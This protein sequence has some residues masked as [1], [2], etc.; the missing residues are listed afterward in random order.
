MRFILILSLFCLTAFADIKNTLFDLYQT[1]QYT[2]ACNLGLTRLYQNRTN[3]DFIS[4][5][6]FSCL[7][8]GYLNRLSYP[9]ARLK[10]SKEARSN[11]A[12]LSVIVMQEKLLLHSM[13]DGYKL[14]QLKLPTTDFILSKVYDM[15]AALTVYKKT[16]FY[17]F[18]DPKNDKITY[19]L[20]LNDA[21]NIVIEKLYNL[22]IVKKVIFN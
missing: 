16:P 19:K 6:A 21:N 3:E 17:I 4:L 11:A 20:Y 8:A 10:K 15:Y 7:N 22:T 12:Y 1:N 2:K 13:L 9:I 5:Y 14:K 18:I